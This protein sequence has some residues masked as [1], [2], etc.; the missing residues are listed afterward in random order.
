MYDPCG[1]PAHL[2]NGFSPTGPCLCNRVES[3]RA[4]F[5]VELRHKVAIA[6]A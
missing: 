1:T 3:M 4:T 2:R 6:N 5:K